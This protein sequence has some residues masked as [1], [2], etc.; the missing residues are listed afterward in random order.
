M[1]ETETIACP[2]CKVEQDV[3]YI[4]PSMHGEPGTGAKADGRRNKIFTCTACGHVA[5]IHTPL[6]FNDH[7]MDL[8]IQFYPEHL[9]VEN[10]EY[11]V[12]IIWKWLSRWKNS[13][14]NS[15]C[16]CQIQTS[17]ETCWWYF[18]WMK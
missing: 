12:T 14:R 6:L 13:G 5:Q 3:T 18:R 16:L 8:K 10:P 11:V 1:I 4:R 2:A 9:L 15:D 7:R 17:R